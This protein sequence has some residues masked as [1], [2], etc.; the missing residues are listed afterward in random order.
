MTAPPARAGDGSANGFYEQALR[1]HLAS[2]P[3]HEAADVYKFTHQSVFGPG[4]LIPSAEA[5]L[6]YLRR[7]TSALKPW[8]ESR[9]EPRYDRLGSDPDLVRVNLRPFLAAGGSLERLAEAAVQTAATVKGDA[10]R[11]T[12]RRESALRILEELGET[13]VAQA[14]R[15]RI[16]EARPQGYPAYHHGKRYSERYVPAYRVIDLRFYQE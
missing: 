9:P 15:A 6:R 14:L 7:E 3:G 8:N 13:E 1:E 4:H 2:Y 11:M 10:E 5:A 12:A 16:D